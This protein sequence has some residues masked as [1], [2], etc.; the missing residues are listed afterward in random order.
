M[1]GG[2]LYNDGSGDEGS[3]YGD[4][5]AGSGGCHQS[6]EVRRKISIALQC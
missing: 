5:E 1:G 6:E 4:I 2:P 3:L